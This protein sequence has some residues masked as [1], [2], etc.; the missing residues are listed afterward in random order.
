MV[1]LPILRGITV[2]L[3]FCQ[4]R[5]QK[6]WMAS[7]AKIEIQTV[8]QNNLP[9]IKRLIREGWRF[10]SSQDAYTCSQAFYDSITY[11]V[12]TSKDR[13]FYDS[14]YFYLTTPHGLQGS[15]SYRLF[16]GTP[17]IVEMPV[18]GA[19]K[20]DRFRLEHSGN[21]IHTCQFYIGIK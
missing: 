14:L 6:G 18:K 12:Y 21:Y 8:N 17:T 4:C 1:R 10:D 3:L 9:Q 16:G 2:L 11:F 15:T 19:Y 13:N 5:S 7:P 20:E